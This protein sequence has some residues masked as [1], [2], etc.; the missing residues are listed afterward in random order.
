M[1]RGLP[2]FYARLCLLSYGD[3]YVVLVDQWTDFWLTKQLRLI[4]PQ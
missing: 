3:D 4:L 2:L 1:Q